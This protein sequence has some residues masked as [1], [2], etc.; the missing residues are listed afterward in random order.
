MP[1]LRVRQRSLIGKL[2]FVPPRIPRTISTR[3]SRTRPPRLLDCD[4]GRQLRRGASLV[5][6]NCTPT[7]NLR[8]QE[9][10]R[11]RSQFATKPPNMATFPSFPSWLQR[12]PSYARSA[13]LAHRGWRPTPCLCLLASP[14][15]PEF[16]LHYTELL[17]I[18]GNMS[19]ACVSGWVPRCRTLLEAFRRRSPARDSETSQQTAFRTVLDLRRHE[20][21]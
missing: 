3:G 12:H 19:T 1:G 2:P 4:L 13:A 6:L 9:R 5:A 11:P 21:E 10:K 8:G 17:R 7:P 18:T 15:R 16:H 20:S 14:R